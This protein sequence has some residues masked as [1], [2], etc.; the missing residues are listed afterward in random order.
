LTLNYP[1]NFE[2]D[3]CNPVR[4]LWVAGSGIDL[5]WV[6]LAGLL[7]A[8]C[9]YLFF[10]Y[11]NLASRRNPGTLSTTHKIYVTKQFIMYSPNR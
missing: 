7:V 2:R 11:K 9:V 1:P 4:D 5:A 8:G 3:L 10:R 6:V